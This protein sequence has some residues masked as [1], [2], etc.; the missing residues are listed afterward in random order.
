VFVSIEVGWEQLD[1][2]ECGLRHWPEE[3][4]M[5]HTL[6]KVTAEP[7]EYTLWVSGDADS[8]N[9]ES[10]TQELVLAGVDCVLD[11]RDKSTALSFWSPR[12]GLLVRKIET[13]DSYHDFENPLA[14]LRAL[15]EIKSDSL[16]IHCHMGVNRSASVASLFLATRGD[17]PGKAVERVLKS[18]ESAL[19][20]YAPIAFNRWLGRSAGDEALD[21]IELFRGGDRRWVDLK[22][23]RDSE[24]LQF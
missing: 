6:S 24:T 23:R 7:G 18:R 8:A 15:E 22:R 14:I 1:V 16:L 19:C 12:D 3:S 20:I 5:R 11:V 21:A 17:T 9:I 10:H 4:A 2:C 13:R